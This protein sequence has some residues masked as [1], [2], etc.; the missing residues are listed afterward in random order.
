[1][2]KKKSLLILP[3]L[4]STLFS[5]SKQ[6]ASQYNTSVD[7][8]I[9]S[10]LNK[11][12]INPSDVTI[13]ETYQTIKTKRQYNT[14]V[15]PSIGDINILVVP[16]LIPGYDTIDKYS[17]ST[18]A[19]DEVKQDIYQAFF[20]EGDNKYESVKSFYKKSS[21]GKLNISGTVT[22]WLDL[23]SLGY[24][25]AS[26]ITLDETYTV[27]KQA[28]EYAKSLGIDTQEYDNDK[29]GYID[30]LWLIYSAHNYNKGGP[31]T[32][33]YNYWAYTS[34][35]NQSG[36]SAQKADVNNPVYN[37][38]GWASYDYMYEGNGT[39]NVDAHT[40]IHETGHFLGLSD[41]Y[42][43]LSTYSPIGK[44][45]MM[46]SNI[47]DLNSYS[48]MLLGWTKPYIALGNGTI[49][50]KSMQN[51]N[52]LIVIPSDNTSI[53]N[54]EFDPF[55]EYILIELYTNEGL[56]YLDSKEKYS[57]SPLAMSSS[58]VRIYHID[59][60]KYIIDKT[61]SSNITSKV[62]E[63]GDVIDTN[64]RLILPITNSL[65]SNTYNTNFNVSI[66]D[67]LF[68]EIRMIERSNKDTFSSGGYQK[69]SSL[70][71]ENDEFTITKYSSFFINEGKFDSGDS[72]STTI[73]I[74]G[75][76]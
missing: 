55:S 62:Y 73:K 68:D 17:D 11:Q 16:V 21:Y 52:A 19:K 66:D 42:S 31:I 7:I 65:S 74:G 57:T 53:E 23:S 1:M 18:D 14:Q 30:G 64:H 39:K 58:G 13:L 34:W 25:S 12:I 22:D 46:D 63:K 40:Y 56:N 8:T 76:K 41:Y 69:D 37:L 38:F 24:E 47:I 44:V 75:I 6:T 71:K 9:E 50:L 26:D 3:I 27:A 10:N 5:C 35:G 67:N 45:D 36:S 61:D 28:V 20:G 15:M 59:N 72:F 2:I 49:N 32:D 33:D 54:N 29:D 4:L 43:D 48:K 70:F 60:R 51:E